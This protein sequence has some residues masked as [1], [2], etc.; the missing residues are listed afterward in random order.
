PRLFFWRF[1]ILKLQEDWAYRQEYNEAEKRLG[2]RDWLG[3]HNRDSKEKECKRKKG[4][5]RSVAKSV[6]LVEEVLGLLCFRSE[7]ETRDPTFL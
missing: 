6:Q 2:L 3:L 1:F 4:K 7:T 5:N